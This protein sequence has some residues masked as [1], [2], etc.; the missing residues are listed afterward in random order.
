[1]I[2]V[3]YATE[4]GST[5]EVAEAVAT[6]LRESGLETDVQP[7]REVR[8]LGPYSAFALG[9]PLIM[10]RLHK[11]MLRFLSRN[12]EALAER[13]VALFALGPCKDPHDDDEWRE[14][15]AQ[16]DGELAKVPWLEPVA[17]EL[18]GGKY[19]LAKLRWPLNKLAGQVPPSDIRDWAAIRDW[20]T[21][22]GPILT[23]P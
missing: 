12:R 5:Q 3:G 10:H 6:A 17:T 11:D 9:A 2:L 20:A 16:L 15:Q 19:D 8:S 7:V 13:P 21:S 22:V 4:Y 23:A 14:C 18:F 1:M